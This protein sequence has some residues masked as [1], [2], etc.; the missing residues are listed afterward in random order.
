MEARTWSEGGAAKLLLDALKEL[1]RS[2][3]AAEREGNNG[4]AGV[5]ALIAEGERL[6]RR[7][8]EQGA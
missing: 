6:R 4:L 3:D 7:A 5:R 2:E 1:V 8:L